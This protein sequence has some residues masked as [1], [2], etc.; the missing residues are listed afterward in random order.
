MFILVLLLLPGLEQQLC[1]YVCVY[2]YL[3]VS[4]CVCL[5]V[6]RIWSR[7]CWLLYYPP[8]CSSRETSF[9][10]YEYYHI[11]QEHR[12]KTYAVVPSVSTILCS[13]MSSE[14]FPGNYHRISVFVFFFSLRQLLVAL[15]S[16]WNAW[17]WNSWHYLSCT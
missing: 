13:F 14:T 7:L 3:H 12:P 17:V 9:R 16:A 11:R 8:F 15:K 4:V 5:H 1:V 10:S 2:V 6:L